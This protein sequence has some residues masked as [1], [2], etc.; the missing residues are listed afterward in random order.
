[1]GVRVVQLS[2]AMI[3]KNEERTLARLLH[4][5]ATFCDELVVVDTGSTDGTVSI[6][7][8]AGAKVGHFTWCDDFSAARNFSF[9]QTSGDWI[10]WLDA[11]DWV[12][13]EA[14]AA[15]RRLKATVMANADIDAIMAP[16]HWAFNA[17]G[18]VTE[19]F[20]RERFVRRSA[21]F[22]WREPVH[23]TLSVPSVRLARCLEAVV[24]HHTHTDNMPRKKGRNLAIY[25]K[26]INIETS[27]LHTVYQYAC[28]LQWNSRLADAVHAFAAF[29]RRS[30]VAPDLLGEQYLA[31]IKMGECSVMTGQPME[32][33]RAYESA[34]ALDGDRAEAMTLAG[35]LHLSRKNF[36][37]AQILL[38]EAASRKVPDYTG[39]YVFPWF[40][41]DRPL[42]GLDLCLQHMR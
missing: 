42:R 22:V 30:G 12:N 40:Y 9:A 23:E 29:L 38:R 16:Y 31:W 4:C 21:G 15:I 14:Q 32:G 20:D 1:M 19:R 2:L 34:I 11:D 27:S 25:E 10:V 33:L 7:Q 35:E 13:P 6:A 26:W 3:V 36:T 28:E 5:A 41:G 18:E 37:M 39:K 17:A 24:E 8:A